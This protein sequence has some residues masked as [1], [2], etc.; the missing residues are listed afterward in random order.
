LSPKGGLARRAHLVKEM[1]G[2]Y[3]GVPVFQLDAGD[4]FQGRGLG[5]EIRDKAVIEAMNRMGV[6]ACNVGSGDIEGGAERFRGATSGAKFPFVSASFVY[7][8]TQAYLFTPSVSLPVGGTDIALLGLD[9][10]P[11]TTTCKGEKGRVVEQMKVLDAVEKALPSARKGNGPVFI[12]AH[13]PAYALDEITKR[14]PEVSMILSAYEGTPPE[15]GEVLRDRKIVSCGYWGMGV[16]EVRGYLNGGG[17][18]HTESEYHLLDDSVPSDP[19]IAQLISAALA[20]VSRKQQTAAKDREKQRLASIEPGAKGCG[21][22][23]PAQYEVWL[24]SAH[25]K[26]LLD[27]KAPDKE[28]RECLKCHSGNVRP[29]AG[30]GHGGPPMQP[31]DCEACHGDGRNH[32]LNPVAGYGK[33]SPWRCLVCHDRENSPGFDQEKY[34]E[35]IRH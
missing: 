30:A 11:G 9:Y 21:R 32:S 15:T 16:L 1:Q 18:L 19:G 33:V 23:H 25:A 35:K 34:L 22:C 31:V 7:A 24:G 29:G 12:L 26:S 13:A 28:K 5:E 20:D 2:K 8:D 4:L 17:A 6:F 14:F 3:R 27:L 10:T